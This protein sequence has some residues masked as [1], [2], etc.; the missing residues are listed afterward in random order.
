MTDRTASAR[1]VVG[2]VLGWTRDG[3][4]ILGITLALLLTLEGLYRAQ[5][6]MRHAI[7]GERREL[8]PDSLRGSPYATERWWIAW[9]TSDSFPDGAARYD[10]YRGWWKGP[11]AFGDIRVDSAGHRRTVQPPVE[12]ASARLVFM[13]GGSAMWGLTARDS[14]TIPS[15][16]TAQLQA[17]GLT[18]VEVVNLAR[19]G[20]N[21]TQGVITLLLELRRGNVPDV[22]VFLDGSNDVSAA[23]QAGEAGH[24]I[25]EEAT[26]ALFERPSQSFSDHFLGLWR[27]SELIQRITTATQHPPPA[28]PLPDVD[29]VCG[30]VARQYR[31]LVRA[32]EA[33]GREY[34]FHAIFLWQPLRATTRK[35]LTA[36]ERSLGAKPGYR[37]LL[38]P[39]AG[40]VD[41]VMQDRLGR[42]YFA[43]DALFDR[44]TATVFLDDYG[45]VT[46]KANQVVADRIAELVSPLLRRRSQP[47]RPS[48]FP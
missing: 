15:L 12:T 31:N 33:M 14:F 10:P 4:L 30:D 42:T 21:V 6:A 35:P 24:V 13:L 27:R 5:G 17:A 7:R 18:Q 3:W 36:W 48:T 28:R 19:L 11:Y 25:N 47:A 20:Y 41:S 2:R 16:V 23:Y 26:A 38:Q 40:K 46:E 29:R 8:S 34:G 32:V 43:L 45:H 9:R 37:Q 39:C 44:D 1:R 22:V